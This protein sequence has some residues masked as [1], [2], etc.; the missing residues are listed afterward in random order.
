MKSKKKKQKKKKKERKKEK[1]KVC[2][3]KSIFMSYFSLERLFHISEKAVSVLK[4]I[5]NA[6]I[7]VKIA[8][9]LKTLF[10]GCIR[11]SSWRLG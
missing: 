7:F 10:A 1:E 3:K 11:V 2:L 9:K 4:V 5:F 6:S 8:E